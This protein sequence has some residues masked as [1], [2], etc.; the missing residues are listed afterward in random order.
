[1]VTDKIHILI[2]LISHAA[3][4]PQLAYLDPCLLQAVAQEHP[5][6]HK[7][8]QYG[9]QS[10]HAVEEWRCVSTHMYTYVY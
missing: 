6:V 4:L 8:L 2:I 3:R 1:M 7:L 10:P 5:H 9:E